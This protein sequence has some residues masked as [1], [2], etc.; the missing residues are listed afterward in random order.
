MSKKLLKINDLHVTIE[1]KNILQGLNLEINSGEIHT[2]LGPNGSGKST[3]AYAIAGHPKYKVTKGKILSKGKNILSQKPDERAKNGI[4][5]S[6]QH[7]EAIP[8]VS[9]SNFLRQSYQA[10]KSKKLRI[11]EFQKIILPLMDKLEISHKF[12]DRSVNEG[13]SGG[14]RKKSE[15]LQALLLE[16]ELIILDETDSGL[17]VDALK[18]VAK[19]IN[20]LLNSQTAVLLITHHSRIL[21]YLQ[22][23]Q[24]SIIKNGKIVEQGDKK[25]AKKIEKEGFTSSKKVKL[26][27][28]D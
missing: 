25:L 24:V 15:I 20:E 23:D 3:L 13:F 9:M 19:G 2:L 14:E 6:F 8:G 10:L 26:Q 16:P 11:P 17:D 27:V 21:H 18:I 22:P 4:F 28:I 12:L 1:D 5:L 7:P